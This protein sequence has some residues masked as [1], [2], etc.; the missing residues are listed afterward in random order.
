MKRSCFCVMC[1]TVLA[2]TL[3]VLMAPASVANPAPPFVW[4]DDMEGDISGYTTV[5]L[6][7]GAAPHFHWDTYMAYEGHSWWVGTFDYDTDGGYGNS[8]DDRLE[9]PEISANPVPV[10]DVSWAA[11]KALYRD[12]PS[13]DGG[14][15]HRDGVMPILTFAYRHDSEV[16]YDHTYVQAESSGVYVN[17]NRGYDG[18]QPWTDIGAYGF[19]LSAYDDPLNVRFRFLS[20]GA[21]SDEDGLYASVAG[22]F[23][24]DNIKIYDFNTG[25][26]LFYDSEPGGREGECVPAVPPAAGDYWHLIDRPCPAYSDPHSWWCGDDA[27]T[28]LVPPNLADALFSPVIDIGYAY[29]CTCYFAMHFAVPTLD[30]DYVTI[31]V[32]VGSGYYG[33]ASFWGDMESCD[34]WAGTPYNAGF[35]IGQFGGG[36]F[37]EAGAAFIMYTTDNGCGPAAAGDAGIMID[38]LW[39][40]TNGGDPWEEGERTTNLYYAERRSSPARSSYGPL[41]F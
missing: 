28:S 3:I 13:G 18:R 29:S 12:G 23:A 9:L 32:T 14:G 16:G 37:Y 11:L 41:N 6:T 31:L 19:D 24:V 15:R 36:L 2:L 27:D 35:D 38:D 39:I 8:W 10:R 20:D 40:C 17:L 33:V 7:A 25:D 26:I 5:D 22:G 1:S 4:H 21:W 34:G 30:N